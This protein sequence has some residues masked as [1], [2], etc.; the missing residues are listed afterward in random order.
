LAAICLGVAMVLYP[1]VRARQ[2]TNPIVCATGEFAFLSAGTIAGGEAR[3]DA[4]RP[5]LLR[6]RGE[7][8]LWKMRTGDL[9]QI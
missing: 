6:V 2:T 1:D 4:G 7:K 3:R 8:K 9:D 5:K